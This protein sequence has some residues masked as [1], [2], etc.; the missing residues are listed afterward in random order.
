M[1]K[2]NPNL[3]SWAFIGISALKKEGGRV[4]KIHALR[5]PSAG[6]QRA[7]LHTFISS[8]AFISPHK[9]QHLCLS[10][11]GASEGSKHQAQCL[12]LQSW[13]LNAVCPPS[14]QFFKGEIKVFN[15]I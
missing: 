3:A 7:T 2:A 14:L 12:M 11:P 13:Q 5:S 6:T 10:L 4:E 15:D 9:E 1:K 8:W